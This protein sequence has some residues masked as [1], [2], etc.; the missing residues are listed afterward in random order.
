[1]ATERSAKQ[2]TTIKSAAE[3]GVDSW[4]C[5][6]EKGEWKRAHRTQRRALFTPH[7]VS[8][9]PR[10]DV[11][12]NTKRKT[13]GRFVG[14]VDAL[15]IEDDY[16]DPMNA[17]RVLANAWVGVTTMCEEGNVETS[18]EGQAPVHDD[19]MP[20]DG[21][22]TEGKLLCCRTTKSDVVIRR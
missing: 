17:R 22:K 9:G 8:G 20:R 15:T 14:I 13:K 2:K 3:R 5:S 19:H 18:D 4:I 6:G 11:V 16:A 21:R 10:G 7:R 1:M 12:M